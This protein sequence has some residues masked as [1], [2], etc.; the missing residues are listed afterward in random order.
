[1]Q[2]SV[3]KLFSEISSI[4]DAIKDLKRG[5]FVIVVDDV[6][7]ENEGDLICSAQK[8]TPAGINFMAKYARGLICVALT[9]ERIK[10]LN[11]FPMTECNTAL[12]H[13]NF[14]VSVDAKKG[15]TTGISAFDRAKTIKVLIDPNAKPEDLAIPGHV[16][17]IR[18]KEGGVLVRAGHT[19]AAVDLARLAGHYPAGV[20][21]EI[22]ADDGSMARMPE[23]V[24]FAKK[25]GFKI[26]TIA[27]LIKYR[28]TREKL[29][30]RIISVELPTEFGMFELFLYK[31]KIEFNNHLALVKKIPGSKK[32]PLVRVHSQCLTGDIFHSRKC[33]CGDQLHKS[34]SM[35]SREGGALIYLP[36]EGRGIGLEDKLRAYKLQSEKKLDTVEA[37]LY[38]G[39]PDDLRDYG[40][41]AQILLDLGFT[42][43][44]LLTNNPRKIVGLEGYGIT[45]VD[46]LPIEVPPNEY[47]LNY[48]K[49]KKK[50][51]KHLIKIQ[52]KRGKNE[53]F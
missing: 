11:L 46:R 52:C 15:V 4:E 48:L 49:T 5:R 29:V 30:D 25:H 21:C 27:D 13:T 16:F 26:I 40:I 43:I 23:L 14:T 44:R 38:L 24:K 17:P 41:G 3:K 45:I 31:D 42:S 1:M 20:I 28:R 32:V 7:R 39:Y 47:S 36:Q 50:K 37:N 53:S 51:L 34:L 9:E 22:M 10:Q 6:K 8:I 35:I 33:D 19:E 18:A 2:K 12:H